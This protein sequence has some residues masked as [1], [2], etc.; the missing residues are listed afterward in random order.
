MVRR[1]GCLLVAVL[2]VASL[3]GCGTGETEAKEEEESQ[4]AVAMLE[5]ANTHLNRVKGLE[6]VTEGVQKTRS[7]HRNK[8]SH[9]EL[10]QKIRTEAGYGPDRFHVVAL[11]GK[12]KSEEVYLTHKTMYLKDPEMNRWEKISAKETDGMALD[13]INP[14]DPKQLL[15][16]LKLLRE[17][18][19]VIQQ[20][21]DYLLELE[22]TGERIAPYI[23]EVWH[24]QKELAVM[25][26]S[27]D[28]VKWKDHLRVSRI[29]QTIRLDA[30][31]FRPIC[32]EQKIHAEVKVDGFHLTSEYHLKTDVKETNRPFQI[33]AQVKHSAKEIE[34]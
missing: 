1:G 34:P 28:L 14:H 15:K 30:K 12:S 4:R 32:L 24:G 11:A 16:K 13:L 26:S 6:Y 8:D 3:T 9:S 29:Q 25:D 18:W 7:Y 31:T 19:S 27:P 33:P 23:R 5:R 20:Q 21:G 10:S 17:D 22:L 2:V